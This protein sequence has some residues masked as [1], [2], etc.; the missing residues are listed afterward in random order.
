MIYRIPVVFF[1]ILL[2]LLN[3]LCYCQESFTKKDSLIFEN[4]YNELLANDFFKK[5]CDTL[6]IKKDFN[7]LFK[8]RTSKN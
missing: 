3:S 5:E 4:S 2:I 8:K 7:G 6:F 1:T